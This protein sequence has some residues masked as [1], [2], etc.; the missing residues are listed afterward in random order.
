M[1]NSFDS[2]NSETGMNEPLNEMK[3]LKEIDSKAREIS[4]DIENEEN[5]L[6]YKDDD[7]LEETMLNAEVQA[8]FKKKKFWV[9]FCF[10]L[11]FSS[12]PLYFLNYFG[13][14]CN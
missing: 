14:F 4:K 13:T 8:E 3:E 11:V 10:M 5:G 7:E 12:F 6:M 9:L 2:K 1:R